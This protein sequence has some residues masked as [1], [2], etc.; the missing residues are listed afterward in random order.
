[1]SNIK[2]P[3]SWGSAY[4]DI[5]QCI[6]EFTAEELNN[7]LTRYLLPLSYKRVNPVAYRALQRLVLA[8]TLATSPEISNDEIEEIETQLTQFVE[9]FYKTYYQQ[10]QDRLS[11][12]T[13]TIHALLHIP[14]DVRNWG[15][16]L[17]FS[18]VPLV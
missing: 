13:Y 5:A 3:F 9:W 17:Y 6:K 12:C 15:S 14:R 11:A 4:L 10:N 16:A 7:F 2:A 8:I 1:M 18:Q